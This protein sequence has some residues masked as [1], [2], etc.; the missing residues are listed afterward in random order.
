MTAAFLALWEKCR[1]AF[2]QERTWRKAGILASGHLL[3]QGRHTITATLSALGRQQQDWSAIYRL[4]EREQFDVEKI[5]T[6]LRND[7]MNTLPEDHPFL[8][9]L[10]DTLLP[11]R[12][13][14]VHGTTWKRDP[15]GPKFT[16]NLIWA[17]RFLQFSAVLPDIDCRCR[18]IPIHFQHCPSPQKPSR[19]ATVSEVEIYLQQQK[20]M[21]LPQQA[22]LAIDELRTQIPTSRPLVMIGDG[23][24]TNRTV[25]QKLPPN[26]T[27]IGRIRKDAKLF[28]SVTQ[29]VPQ[30]GRRRF[31]GEVLPTPE[32]IRQDESIPWREVSAVT[33][34]RRHTFRIKSIALV[35]SKITGEQNLKLIIIQ[36]LAYRLTL[37]SKPI[38]RDPAYLICTDFDLDDAKILQWYLWRWEIELNF[39]DEKSLIGIHD[40]QVRIKTAVESLPAF[41]TA[42]YG[43]LL[44]AGTEAIG[45]KSL[46]I[47]IPKWQ[48]RDEF[49]RS[50]TSNLLTILRQ[51]S[52]QTSV[53]NNLSGFTYRPSPP[54]NPL[55]CRQ[56]R[57]KTSV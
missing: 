7:V 43:L 55:F 1:P 17:Q 37:K 22:R 23:G 33:D 35:R 16:N 18:G 48:R 24:Y 41:L 46:P 20:E 2:Q 19:K 40:P 47:I 52:A 56:F 6:T 11:K 3:N 5:F 28:A 49:T 32:A 51:E 31:Y 45:R 53:L 25:C 50:S 34:N 44:L 29:P 21:R 54:A 26:T 14:H 30:H 4:F 57:Y 8:V 9:L 39:R 38:Y 10:D 13:K 12:G 27:F 15:L 36:P 42:V